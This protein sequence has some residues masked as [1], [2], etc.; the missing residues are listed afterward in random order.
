[1]CTRSSTPTNKDGSLA[2]GKTL[3]HVTSV[4]NEWMY[5]YLHAFSTTKLNT[6]VP[7][8][9]SGAERVGTHLTGEC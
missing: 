6:C 1:M 2:A 9:S 5:T 4:V 8:H 7:T 3:K